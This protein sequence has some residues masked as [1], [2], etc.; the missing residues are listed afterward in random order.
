MFLPIGNGSKYRSPRM[1]N[2]MI[3]CTYADFN[4]VSA[5]TTGDGAM[6]VVDTQTATFS[7]GASAGTA[8][9][10]MG[11]VD[12]FAGKWYA[13]SCE[14]SELTN[15]TFDI[16]RLQGITAETEGEANLAG[17]DVTAQAGRRVMTCFKASTTESKDLRMGLVIGVANSSVTISKPM[18]QEMDDLSEL[19]PY[20][21]PTENSGGNDYW[22]QALDFTDDGYWDNDN[23]L[24]VAPTAIDRFPVRRSAVG[25][26]IS[27]SFGNTF[28]GDWPLRISL[29]LNKTGF[30]LN[31]EA[32]RSMQTVAD[33]IETILGDTA[34]QIRFN[35][36]GTLSEHDFEDYMPYPKF[37][38]INLGINDIFSASVSDNPIAD[39]QAALKT[40]IARC[41]VKDVT[42][43]CVELTPAGDAP[44]YNAATLD[45]LRI[46]MW[47]A[48]LKSYCDA[49]GFLFVDTYSEMEGDANPD[50]LSDTANGDTNEYT[51]DG[52]HPDTVDGSTAYAGLILK[53]VRK[54]PV[55]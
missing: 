13:I 16:F 38:V 26:I 4:D 43:I 41:V 33:N 39:M 54:L 21:Y 49:Q 34:P 53:A 8:Y 27:D 48:W 44:G 35:A 40:I 45:K 15:Y 31:G 1:V 24:Y 55:D 5:T 25:I 9:F 32:G 12:L 19:A 51:T 22:Y 11:S 42:P 10:A 28:N 52:L 2:N 20:V 30:Y 14:V 36:G 17:S 7:C 23:K 3:R 18:I 37:A 46:N 6:T 29:A 50:Q 47:N